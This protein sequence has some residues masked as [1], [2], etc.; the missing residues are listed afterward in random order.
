M[1]VSQFKN[2]R[3]HICTPNERM[4][5]ERKRQ[6]K[7]DIKKREGE[8]EKRERGRE[9]RERDRQTDKSSANINADFNHH[10]LDRE[11]G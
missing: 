7:D 3:T 5:K 1:F 2:R 4:K 8:K 9:E 6:K 11:G 10:A